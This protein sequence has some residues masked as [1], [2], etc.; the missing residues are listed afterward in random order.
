MENKHNFTGIIIPVIIAVI[1]LTVLPII[2]SI[3]GGCP[4]CEDLPTLYTPTISISNDTLTIT[5]NSNNG[6]FVTGY[7]IYVDGVLLV[8]TTS[9]TYDLSE[10]LTEIGT[11]EIYVTVYATLFA[12]SEPSNIEEYVVEPIVEPTEPKLFEIDDIIPANAVVRI[13]WTNSI[14]KSRFSPYGNFYIRGTYN[15]ENYFIIYIIS[16]SNGI[17]K[18]QIGINNGDFFTIISDSISGFNNFI[19]PYTNY[20][21]D[22]AYC[23]IFIGV[24]I[25]ISQVDEKMDI[26]TWEVLGESI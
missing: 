11:Y 21:G 1:L 3:N 23:D 6:A 25:I 4:P 15:S 20:T 19:S 26:F 16:T 12:D 10:E 13:G 14:S 5:P 7:K 9:T 8:T 24:P 17:S 18:F 22:H 2:N